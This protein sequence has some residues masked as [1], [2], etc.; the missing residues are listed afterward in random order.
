MILMSHLEPAF[1]FLDR[2]GELHILYIKK[3][4]KV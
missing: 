4:E 1:F 2:A 3:G